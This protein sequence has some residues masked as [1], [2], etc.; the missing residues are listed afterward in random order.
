MYMWDKK[1]K[2]SF[3]IENLNNLS[4]GRK[5]MIMQIVCVLLPLLITDSAIC[6]LIVNS[7]KKATLQEMNNIADSVKYTV[8]DSIENAVG[9]MQNIYSNRYV[10]EFM[11]SE[12][13][14]TLDYYNQYVQFI[15][16][17]LYTVSVSSSHYNTVIY[18]DN[19]GI[20][21]GG[22]FKRLEDAVDTQWY[23]ELEES[24]GEI[25]VFSD[26]VNTGLASQRVIS[27][28]RR[29][30]YYHKSH[31]KSALKLDLDYSGIARTIANAKYSATLY[32]CEGDRILFS[33]DGRG[34][35]Q[36]PFEHMRIQNVRKA[37]VHKTMN[38]YGSIWD[39]YV[40][41]PET[42]SIAIIM[43]N[44]PLIICL[45]CINVILPFILM[46]LINQ[47]F[48]QRLKELDAVFG[49]VD[50]DELKQLPE[51][52]G[53]DEISVLMTSYNKMARRMNELIQTVY[54]NR[55][56]SQEIDIARQKAE[57][58]ALHSQINPH[59]LFNALESIRMHSVIKKEFE[60]ADMVQKL[61]LMERQNVE[62]GNDFVRIREEIKFI[63]AYLELQK[64]RFG[65]KLSYEINVDEECNDYWLPKL[66]LVTFVENA[67]VHGMESK[68]SSSWVF[69]RIYMQ[70]EVLVMEVEDT[71][72]GMSED[73]CKKFL[74]EM[75][76]VKIEML[77]ENHHV[78][79]LNAA[80]RLKMATDGRVHFEMDSEVGA[81]TIVTI[82][83]P[84]DE[85]EQIQKQK[86]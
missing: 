66:T 80:L 25:I 34:G 23:K 64:Y 3:L 11:K 36:V 1:K 67:C 24:P 38:V 43:D 68:T 62:W 54:K 10:N 21:N 7:D 8:S 59:F 85:A 35:L 61:A 13:T 32:I 83:V 41:T 65:T 22:Y 76:N 84:L 44:L 70:D 47:S 48:T 42:D 53:H 27:L 60:T 49:N 15:K 5:L 12:F 9:L 39:I 57:L 20:V 56:K 74:D 26:Y 71:G 58:L 69:V 77:K 73:K 14:S 51:V 46:W 33:N 79:I 30:D 19:D 4:L 78:G 18:G 28:V 40:M 55:L 63:E 29:M 17:S 72:S 52:K 45:I 2:G 86:R 31:E 50:G 81:G 6:T 16:D 37:G 82:S 75:T